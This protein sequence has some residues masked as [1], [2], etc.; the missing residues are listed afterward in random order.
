MGGR[1]DTLKWRIWVAAVIVAS[2]ALGTPVAL[3]CWNLWQPRPPAPPISLPPPDPPGIVIHHSDTPGS[4]RGQPVGAEW[5]GALHRKRGF[6]IRYRGRLYNIGYH[7]VIREDGT[8][9]SGRPEHCIGAHSKITAYNQYLGICL[10]GNFSEAANPHRFE[11]S[12]PTGQQLRSLIWLCSRLAEKYRFPTTRII[13]HH[14]IRQTACPGERF[15]YHWVLWQI[16]R[17]RPVL[18]VHRERR[19]ALAMRIGP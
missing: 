11:P 12:A 10:V 7:Y 5:I 4:V 17:Y 19:E 14:D 1:S 8:I 16:E 13:R 18:R 3:V 2:V 9:D 15:P 6:A